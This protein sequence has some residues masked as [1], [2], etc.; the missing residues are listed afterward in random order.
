MHLSVTSFK[1]P[2]LILAVLCGASL[3]GTK[4]HAESC[5]ENAAANCAAASDLSTMTPAAAATAAASAATVGDTVGDTGSDVNVTAALNS[6]P[7]TRVR[8]HWRNL[9]ELAAV[10]AGGTTWYWIEEERQVA[11]WD[12]PT[13][14]QKLTFDDEIMIFDGNTFQTN[15]SW[16]TYAGGSSHLLGRSNGL[17]MWESFAFGTGA[18][19]F[20]EYGIEAREKISVNDLI[21]TNSTGL[22]VGE[23]F[24]RIGQ[25]VNQGQTGLGWDIARYSVGLGH[26]AH[27]RIDGELVAQD[28]LLTPDFRWYYSLDSLNFTRQDGAAAAESDS[29]VLHNIGFE[30]R[31]VALDNYL[32]PGQ[33]QQFFGSANFSD[34]SLRVAQGGGTRAKANATHAEGNALIAGWHYED[35]PEKG[36][37]GIGKTLNLATSVGYLYRREQVGLWQDRL[38][39]LHVPGP[40]IEGKVI[41]DNWKFQG[42]IR[43]NYDFV[44]V[45]AL[46]WQ[47]YQEQRPGDIG[48][49]ILSNSG[50]YYGF[51]RSLRVDAELQVSR[52]ELGGKLYWAKYDSI[53]G[54]ERELDPDHPLGVPDDEQAHG[55]DTF[56][57]AE[58]WLRARVYE[59]AYAQLRL[60]RY[61]RKGTLE[62]FRAEEDMTRINL[63]VGIGF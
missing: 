45:N 6:N 3:P 46:S 62:E 51:G 17:G 14:E 31:I 9:I 15:Y 8:H 18:S 12:F 59:D 33:R 30:G 48:K 35:I 16:H 32:Q 57:D 43:G 37:G 23:F 52:F 2:L 5:K 63:E 41:G 19:L 28:L 58:A 38:G 13:W 26:T 36:V 22:P 44:G 55:R 61:Y 56:F 10:I 21:M 4:A 47:Q 27:A 54:F 34:F 7:D 11:D 20:W 60:G 29:A 40:A 49:F 53:E 25:Y 50:Y 24:H 42:Q 39:G 1:T